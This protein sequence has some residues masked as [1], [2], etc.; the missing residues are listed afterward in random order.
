MSTYSSAKERAAQQSANQHPGYRPCRYCGKET[1]QETLV[2]YGARCFEC[3]EHYCA[4]KN[5]AHHHVGAHAT[6][7]QAAALRRAAAQIGRMPAGVKS[8][9]ELTLHG[10]LTFEAR[11]GRL[12]SGAQR[13]AI[14]ELQLKLGHGAEDELDVEQQAHGREPH[15][16]QREPL[17]LRREPLD[18]PQQ[19]G[20]AA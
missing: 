18:L 2:E 10:L 14:R 13:A 3:Y 6:H 11:T 16:L 12:S 19:H 7:E 8:P 15:G 17:D 5:T 1:K 9:A 20:S 4:E